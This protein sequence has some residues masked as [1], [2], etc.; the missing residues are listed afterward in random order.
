[1]EPCRNMRLALGGRQ[2]GGMGDVVYDKADWQRGRG[3]RVGRSGA[4]CD[5]VYCMVR[6]IFVGLDH[7][8]AL[9]TGP[10]RAGFLQSH[11]QFEKAGVRCSFPRL[12]RLPALQDLRPHPRHHPHLRGP[13]SHQVSHFHC[14]LSLIGDVN[15]TRLY[16]WK[17]PML[18]G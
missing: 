2:V 1:M 4:C 6:R 14:R 3:Q 8:R 12:A 16:C 9:V 15:N 10:F 11:V 5:V 17:I 18:H 7:V 13:S